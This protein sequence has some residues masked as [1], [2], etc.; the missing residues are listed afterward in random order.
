MRP[1]QQRNDVYTPGP[2][3]DH[4]PNTPQGSVYPDYDQDYKRGFAFQV[5]TGRGTWTGN[6]K[7]VGQQLVRGVAFEAIA[8]GAHQVDTAIRCGKFHS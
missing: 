8:P 7:G 2:G 4:P 1:L 5:Y 3:L 6:R